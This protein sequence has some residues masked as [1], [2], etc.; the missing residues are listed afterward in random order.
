MYTQVK[1]NCLK[2]NYLHKM[3]LVLSN[4]QR[5]ICHKTQPTIYSSGCPHGVMVEAMNCGIVVSETNDRRVVENV[6]YKLLIGCVNMCI[7]RVWHEITHK[8]A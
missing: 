6:T 3:D 8:G 7:N 5:L 1:L 4:L 2:E